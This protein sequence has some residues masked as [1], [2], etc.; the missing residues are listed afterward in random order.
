MHKLK[1]MLSSQK[2]GPMVFSGGVELFHCRSLLLLKRAKAQKIQPDS[3][4]SF[5]PQSIAYAFLV[6]QLS[7]SYFWNCFP[8]YILTTNSKVPRRRKAHPAANKTWEKVRGFCD[9]NP[10]YFITTLPQ[11]KDFWDKDRSH[12][13]RGKAHIQGICLWKT[14]LPHSLAMDLN[15]RRCIK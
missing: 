12:E 4:I 1:K 5:E 6:E 2:E 7:S 11:L 9:S 3:A 10:E 14:T 8:G 15:G 13:E